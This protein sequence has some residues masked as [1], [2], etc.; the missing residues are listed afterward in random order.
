[1][2]EDRIFNPRAS[3]TCGPERVQAPEACAEPPKRKAKVPDA[4]P[5]PV[6][7]I[8][9]TSNDR[10]STSVGAWLVTVRVTKPCRA[11]PVARLVFV[12]YVQWSPGA[13][14]GPFTVVVSAA[15][16]A[17]GRTNRAARASQ[18]RDRTVSNFWGRD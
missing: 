1:R 15:A 11:S 8:M 13:R 16:V 5:V 18:P 3:T 14:A 17:A 10:P 4:V 7:D 9:Y 2:T 12:R 6:T